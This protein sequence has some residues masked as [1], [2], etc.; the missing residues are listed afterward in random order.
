MDSTESV[1][2]VDGYSPTHRRRAL[3]GV[4]VGD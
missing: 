1:R 3:L 4:R 2:V